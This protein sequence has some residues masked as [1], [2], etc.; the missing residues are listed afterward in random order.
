MAHVVVALA[1]PGLV[2]FDLGCALQAF[3]Y[4]PGADRD[5]GPY[6]FAV[7]G[8]GG[9]RVVTSDGFAL[10][11]EHDLTA[12]ARA[13]T[14]VVP[15]YLQAPET[16]PSPAVL[17]ALR[18]AHERGA[19]VMSICIGA[20]AL[21]HAGLLDG[22]RATTHWA[23]AGALA[24]Q[25]PAVE[26]VADVLYVDEGDVLTSAGLA[27]GLDL[28]LHVVRRDHGAAAAAELARWNVVAPH[29]DG[30]QAQF[31]PAPVASAPDGGLGATRAWALERLDQPLAL[32]DLAA[33][34][35]CTERTLTRRFHAETGT[36]PK[37]WLLTARLARARELLETT[38]DAIERVAARAGFPTAAALR[39]RF[40][41]ELGTTPT[42]YRRAFR[43]S[44][45][46][47]VAGSS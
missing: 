39:A 27:A 30:G 29:R 8:P 38:D 13:E 25:F 41:A 47:P 5:A 9:R 21:A 19:R 16:A 31:T 32:A 15:G 43:G 12:L 24:E 18:A 46:L 28:A 10:T 20:F 3:A 23:A 22:R 17:R 7:C 1:L 6:D 45:V 35:C 26:V 14:V 36:T 34:A 44:P 2:T 11:L 40:A 4:A 42:A 33:H 37:Q